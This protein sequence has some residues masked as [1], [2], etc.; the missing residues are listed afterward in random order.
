MEG[1][2]VQNRLTIKNLLDIV[3]ESIWPDLKINLQLW[4]N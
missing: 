3:I 1:R 2:G 4:K